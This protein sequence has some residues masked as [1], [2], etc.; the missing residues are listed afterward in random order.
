MTSFFCGI[1]P[2]VSEKVNGDAEKKSKSV[3]NRPRGPGAKF[4]KKSLDA[5]IFEKGD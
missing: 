2:D 1:I 3:K 5:L 4:W